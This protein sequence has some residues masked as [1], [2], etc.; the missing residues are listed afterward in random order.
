L[1]LPRL[2]ELTA[3]STHIHIEHW[4][5]GGEDQTLQPLAL[6]F[7]PTTYGRDEG[8]AY[9]IRIDDAS[10]QGMYDHLSGRGTKA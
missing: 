8:P 1:P 5:D 6:L 4:G 9:V 3:M 10:C 7:S 2:L